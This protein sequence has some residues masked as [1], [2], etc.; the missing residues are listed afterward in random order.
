[1]RQKI[2]PDNCIVLDGR[3]DE[4]VWN[5]VPEVTGFTRMLING[6]GLVEDQT[7]VRIIPCQNYVYFGIKCVDPDMAFAKSYV[8]KNIYQGNS[9]EVFLSPSNNVFQVYNFA[10]TLDGLQQ[11]V[12]YIEGGS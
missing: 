10:L 8:S 9:V 1:M 2:F 6:G 5:E 4:P 3:M 11:T 7:F 12:C